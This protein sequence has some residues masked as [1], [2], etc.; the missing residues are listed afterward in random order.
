MNFLKKRSA[1]RNILALLISV[2]LFIVN[3][4]AFAEKEK[5]GATLIV[6]KKDGKTLRGE[7]LDVK[8]GTLTMLVYENHQKMDFRLDE[9]AELQG[10]R[11]S[12]IAGGLLGG[13]LTGAGI[14]LPV[15]LLF[16]RNVEYSFIGIV[17][18]GVIT[19]SL[20]GLVIGTAATAAT[21]NS[22]QFTGQTPEKLLQAEAKLRPL[23]RYRANR[24]SYWKFMF[25]GPRD[26]TH[27]VIFTVAGDPGK[28]EFHGVDGYAGT[29]SDD[30]KVIAMALPGHPA[31]VFSGQFIDANHMAGTWENNGETWNW[32]AARTSWTEAVKE[33][34]ISESKLLLK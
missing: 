10:L 7:L 24:Y 21:K 13:L 32:T 9:I 20:I 26:E 31:I 23:A 15:W 16:Y 4:T 28:F 33:T 27:V 17:I 22:V 2:I 19:G 3:G 6:Q 5:P 1:V 14:G 29:F 34:P 8:Y 12:S 11:K 25:N 18:V 30:G